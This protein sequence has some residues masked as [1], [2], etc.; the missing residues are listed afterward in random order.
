M[1]NK[2][3]ICNK[4]NT[5]IIHG[6]VYGNVNPLLEWLK[7]LSYEPK[8][9]IDRKNYL[10]SKNIK[11]LTIYEIDELIKYRD[12][13][14]MKILLTKYNNNLCSQSEYTEVFYYLSKSINELI[15]IKLTK[16]EMIIA[17][18]KLNNLSNI[19]QEEL[20]KKIKTEKKIENYL[21]LSMIDSYVFHVISNIDYV[22]G[23]S[24]KCYTLNKKSF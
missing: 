21:N 8:H 20:N 13:E 7:W 19:S 23:I 16:E 9:E 6:N 18:D 10:N 4:I 5:D 22:R 12:Y 15:N 3:I 11:T 1:S 14:R 17:K 2:T 24:K